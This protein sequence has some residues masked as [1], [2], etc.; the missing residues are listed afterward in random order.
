MK[1][2]TL[3]LL[4][5]TVAA[6]GVEPLS[7]AVFDFTS[8][9]EA[10]REL[11]PKIA[12]LLTATLSADERMIA[13]E[14]AEL[15]KALGEQELALSGAIAPADA[16]KIGQLTGAKLLVTG[17]VMQ[18]G[19][20]TLAVAKL[21]GTD[22]GRVFAVKTKLAVNGAIADTLAA[23]AQ[24]IADTAT[25]NAA[26]LVAAP[27][28]PDEQIAK[29]RAALKDKPRATVSVRIPEQHF[30][31]PVIDPAAQTELENLLGQLDF[32]LVDEKSSRR[33]DFAIEGEAF[34]ER[35]MQRGQ[36]IACKARVEVK[37]RNLANGEIVSSDRQTAVAIDLA[38]HIAAKTALQNSAR[39]LAERIIPRISGN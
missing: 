12:P 38:E 22:T 8:S 3:F 10:T 20:E 24:Q 6:L 26:A 35:A 39:Q 2:F 29:L 25:K 7:I 28:K 23:L 31:R 33:A 9:D 17:R 32:K 15:D 34:S 27:P 18:A 36:L 19:T 4:A 30:G 5:T 21:I 16:A 37:V 14:R 13:V 11:A 1:S